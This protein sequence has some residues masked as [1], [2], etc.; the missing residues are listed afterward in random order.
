MRTHAVILLAALSGACAPTSEELRK[1][2]SG[3]VTF[4]APVGYQE[5]YRRAVRMARK[6]YQGGAITA[7]YVV[8]GDL[9]TDIKKGH[10]T[11][12]V[13][14]AL[15]V[16]THLVIDIEYRDMDSSHVDVYYAVRTWRK[17]PRLVERWVSENWDHCIADLNPPTPDTH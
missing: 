3:K 6:C 14:G 9:Y 13:S 4:V 8:T 2:H 16:D 11:F 1:D 10:V 5:A 7:Q 15:G 12:A 17:V